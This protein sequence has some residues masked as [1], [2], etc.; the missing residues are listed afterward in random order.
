MS[1]MVSRIT[2]NLVLKGKNGKRGR[3]EILFEYTT[4]FFNRTCSPAETF[5]GGNMTATLISYL[6]L[7][8]V[9]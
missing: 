5:S 9:F 3:I 2:R 4:V 6:I 7:S 1:R 8:I